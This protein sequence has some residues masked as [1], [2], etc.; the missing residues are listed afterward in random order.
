MANGLRYTNGILG[1]DKHY[2]VFPA[3]SEALRLEIFTFLENTILLPL[4]LS[5][6]TFIECHRRDK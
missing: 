2:Y 6:V 5:N 3:C 1:S 4:A